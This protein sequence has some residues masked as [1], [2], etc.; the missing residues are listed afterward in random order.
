MWALGT[1]PSPDPPHEDARV[2]CSHPSLQRISELD[3][4]HSAVKQTQ[5]LPTPGCQCSLVSHPRSHSTDTLATG[6]QPGGLSIMLGCLHHAEGY[7]HNSAL[8][9]GA[10]QPANPLRTGTH[11]ASL[12][13]PK[14]LLGF[15][16][17]SHWIPPSR[18]FRQVLTLLHGAL[19]TINLPY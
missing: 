17:T 16:V 3:D 2:D 9:V 8:I 18:P 11:T 19:E 6:S 13:A 10:C 1:K 7:H 14:L 5:A 15:A 12:I 4:I